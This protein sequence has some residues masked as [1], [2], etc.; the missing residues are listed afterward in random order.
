LEVCLDQLRFMNELFDLVVLAKRLRTWA[1]RDDRFKPEV[2][3][4]FGR[5]R[6]SWRIR[7]RRNSENH[8]I[9]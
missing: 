2:G 4:L 1:E 7:S 8:G 3:R 9:T 5:G 6:Q